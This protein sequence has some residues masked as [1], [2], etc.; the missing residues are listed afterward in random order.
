[1]IDKINER[2]ICAFK[3]SKKLLS[4]DY[5]DLMYKYCIL[6]NTNLKLS[7]FNEDTEKFYFLTKQNIRVCCDKN[8]WMLA[9][10]F[11]KESYSPI[12]FYMQEDYIIIDFGMNR[13]Y[14]S[15]YFAADKYCKKVYAYE[16]SKATFDFA[17]YNIQLNPA[18]KNK[19]KAYNFGVGN[20]TQQ[21]FLYKPVEHDEA[22]S[23]SIEQLKLLNN[24][25]YIDKEV[26][27][28]KKASDIVRPIIEKNLN[29]KIILKIDIEGAEEAVLEDLYQNKLLQ[30]FEIIIGENH[31]NYKIDRFFKDF[32][33]V[34][35]VRDNENQYEFC[36]KRIHVAK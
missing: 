6:N 15:L 34:G 3:C 25:A 8:F 21:T 19:I 18:L 33:K 11:G 35:M 4:D 31:G 14:A 7:H 17:I 32:E 20:K 24:D 1:M 5:Y 27:N 10:V 28:I 2:K 36:Y 26:I 30:Y 23:T 16:P 13:G 12:F 22:A 29:K 9:G